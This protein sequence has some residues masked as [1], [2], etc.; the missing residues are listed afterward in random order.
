[1]NTPF[2]FVPQLAPDGTARRILLWALAPILALLCV[3]AL[4]ETSATYA[5][6]WVLCAAVV[7]C[8]YAMLGVFPPGRW[9]ERLSGDG[10]LAGLAVA[11]VALL[12]L[13]AAGGADAQPLK[14]EYGKLYKAT[15]DL[16]VMVRNFLFGMAGF[17]A[18]VLAGGTFFGRFNAKMGWSILGGVVILALAG[19]GV[20]LFIDPSADTAVTGT[21]TGFGGNKRSV[22]R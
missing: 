19:V 16:F 9:A 13:V 6:G 10:A 18:L 4:S 7:V 17:A 14:T 3:L 8:A 15:S 5:V 1:M 11:S 21:G 2:T 20:N 22:L 12:G